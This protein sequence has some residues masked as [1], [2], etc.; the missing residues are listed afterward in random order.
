M[1][2]VHIIALSVNIVI[3]SLPFI[4]G[5][6]QYKFKDPSLNG[7]STPTFRPR[8]SVFFLPSHMI[9][10]CSAPYTQDISLVL[11]YLPCPAFSSF[12]RSLI[13]IAFLFSVEI[14][15]ILTEQLNSQIKKLLCFICRWG[16]EIERKGNKQWEFSVL[17]KA[18]LNMKFC[19]LAVLLM[20]IS[21]FIHIFA[22]VPTMGQSFD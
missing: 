14:E 16:W 7:K 17:F 13:T 3:V 11:A 21:L 5:C 9:S 6:N 10:N 19:S 15:H 4:F 12:L 22:L 2:F 20:L 18:V 1:S 8:L